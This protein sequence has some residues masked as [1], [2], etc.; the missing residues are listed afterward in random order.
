MRTTTQEMTAPSSMIT[1]AVVSALLLEPDGRLWVGTRAGGLNVL[2]PATDKFLRL[3]PDPHDAH[4]LPHH[5]VTSIHRDRG[6]RIWAG[7]GGGG[8]A[9]IERTPAGEWSV[10]RVTVAD[11]L[12]NG[13]VVSI[14]EDDDGSLWIGT[15]RAVFGT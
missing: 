1:V 8:L 13:S 6:G 2:D 5:T 14:E 3:A 12:V 7:T 9:R 4:S 11:G 15:R 10:T